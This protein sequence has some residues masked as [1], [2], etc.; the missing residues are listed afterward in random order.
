MED[1]IEFILDLLVDSGMEV[2]S[3]KKISKKIRIPILIFL[4]LI[5]FSV[6]TLLIILG[7]LISKESVLGG[8]LITLLGIILLFLMILKFKKVYLEKFKSKKGE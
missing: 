1:L 5:F 7:V 4:I 6:I 3:N 8:L 2:V